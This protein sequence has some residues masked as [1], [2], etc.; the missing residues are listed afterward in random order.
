[1]LHTKHLALALVEHRGDL[2]AIDIAALATP[3]WFVP[4]TTTL[5]EQLEAFRAH[6]SHFALVVDEYGALQGLV[7]LEDILEEIFGE[8]PTNMRPRNARM[9]AAGLTVPIWWTAPC[10]C[11]IS[12][13]S[14]TG[15]CRTKAPPPSPGWSFHAGAIPDAGQRFAFF[16][17]K[18]EILRRQ[19]NQITAPR[20]SC[21]R[22][23]WARW[24][25]AQISV[26]ASGSATERAPDLSAP[27]PARHGRAAAA[28]RAR[29]HQMQPPPHGHGNVSRPGCR[30]RGGPR[31]AGM[32]MAFIHH[33]QALGRKSGGQFLPD[34][35][36]NAHKRTSRPV[37]ES[38]AIPFLVFYA[39]PPIIE[40]WLKSA[41][42]GSKATSASN[43]TK[44]RRCGQKS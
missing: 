3:P 4:D 17:Y 12:I 39:L 8:F 27:R 23:R 31:M 1:M 42:P 24:L 22:S 9:C 16:G 26:G 35:V 21:H 34:S 36:G 19:R 37:G 41:P 32:A 20:A 43:R 44:K 40:Q 2:A 38:Q 13:A 18:F 29:R 14:W 25:G 6:K 11:A 10:R 28:P 7:T 30:R 15:I 33:F 5:E